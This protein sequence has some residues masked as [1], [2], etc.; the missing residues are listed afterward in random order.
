MSP[1]RS[2]VLESLQQ[3]VEPVAASELARHLGQH[4]NTV[5]EHLD[6]LVERGLAVR[7]P[8]ESRGRGRPAVRYSP[9]TRMSEPDARVRDHAALAL[10]LAE[11]L[12]RVSAQPEADARAAG[13]GW[14]RLLT[15]DERRGGPRSARRRLVGLLAAMRYDPVVRSGGSEI[16][17]RRCPLLDVARRQGRVVCSVH[18]GMISAALEAYGGDAEHVVLAPFAEEGGCVVTLG[19][20]GSAA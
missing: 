2:R 15:G 10:V 4:A 18:H 6:A 7:S 19:P 12:A 8:A 1:A 20:P 16:L 13:R 17:L 3:S 11:H 9:S 14:G 5:R